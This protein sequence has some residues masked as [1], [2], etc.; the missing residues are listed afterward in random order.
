MDKVDRRIYKDD[1]R[2]ANRELINKCMDK[3]DELIG[4]YSEIMKI[5]ERMEEDIRNECEWRGRTNKTVEE[6]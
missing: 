4:G 3:L 2:E 5:I 6:I 1:Y